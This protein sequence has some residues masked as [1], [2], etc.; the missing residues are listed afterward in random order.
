MKIKIMQITVNGSKTSSPVRFVIVF[1]PLYF[2]LKETF[3][4][5]KRPYQPRTF[6]E[7]TYGVNKKGPYLLF[8]RD[9]DHFVL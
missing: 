7:Q 1:F 9:K 4:V 2:V 6:C 8:K 5:R 3:V